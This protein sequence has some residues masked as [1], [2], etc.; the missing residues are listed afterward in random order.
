MGVGDF[1]KPPE[2]PKIGPTREYRDLP[3]EKQEEL[4]DLAAA[5]CDSVFKPAKLNPAVEAEEK[6][7]AKLGDEPPAQAETEAIDWENQQEADPRLVQ[8]GTA[9]AALQS[10]VGADEEERRLNEQQ[11]QADAMPTVEDKQNLFRAI[12][13][14]LRYEKTFELFGGMVRVKMVELTPREEDYIFVEMGKAQ[15]SGA[16]ATEDD[17]MVMFERMRM[18]YSIREIQTSGQE[19]YERDPDSA[20]KMLHT[21]AEAFVGKFKGSILYQSLMQVARVFRAQTEIMTEAA[22]SSDFWIVDGQDSPPPPSPEEPSTIGESLRRAHGDSSKES[23]S[24]VSNG[25]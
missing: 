22:A 6:A 17:W 19:T 25:S 14:G 23:S 24:P 12:L 20:G 2:G 11:L 3:K 7:Q 1:G 10:V 13:G 8:A 4:G 16:V 5:A 21:D 15:S 9:Y 18:M